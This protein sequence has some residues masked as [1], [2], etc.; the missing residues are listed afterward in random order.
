MSI[1]LLSLVLLLVVVVAQQ[2][3]VPPV[4][5]S[6]SPTKDTDMNELQK[7]LNKINVDLKSVR[8]E[9][10]ELVKEKRKIIQQLHLLSAKSKRAK[11]FELLNA[12]DKAFKEVDLSQYQHLKQHFLNTKKLV[13]LSDKLQKQCKQAAHTADHAANVAHSKSKSVTVQTA[14][15]LKASIQHATNSL[16]T[17]KDICDKASKAH[18][19]ATAAVNKLPPV[20]RDVLAKHLKTS[21]EK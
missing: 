13:T 5:E 2:S 11:H 9:H 21:A 15:V 18:D 17:A 3:S 1:R 14:N 19:K 20:I 8:Q 12:V 7:K 16:T 10:S 6:P 4:S